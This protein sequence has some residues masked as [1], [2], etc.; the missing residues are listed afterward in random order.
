MAVVIFISIL[1]E[2]LKFLGL[3]GKIIKKI[4][5]KGV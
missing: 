5:L 1:A 3:C 2:G 4:L